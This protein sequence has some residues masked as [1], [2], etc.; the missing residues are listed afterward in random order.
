MNTLEK[1]LPQLKTL[2]LSG[3]LDTLEVRNKQAIEQKLSFIDFLSIVLNDE[4]ER[5][6]NKKL[7]LRLRRANFQGERTLENFRFD[8][9]NL[10]VNK[11]HIFDLAAGAFIDERVN[12]LIV[13]PTG[14]GKS[15]L[16]QAI[17]HAACLRGREVQMVLCHKM[18]AQLRSSRADGSFDRK[19]RALLQPDLLIIDDFGL[20]PLVPPA[21]DDFHELVSERYERGSI[22]LTSNL[23]FP[24]W[25]TAFPNPVLGAATVDRLRHQAHRVI[26]EGDS[27]RR[28]RPTHGKKGG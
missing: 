11:A 1:M 20:R 12:A 28:P 7:N 26:I 17:G 24:E 18:L 6:E 16:A 22:L 14:V 3:L 23:D 21:D 13:G 25:G 15:H 19:M 5:R 9:A 4:Y 2:R 10:K 8:E 27:Y